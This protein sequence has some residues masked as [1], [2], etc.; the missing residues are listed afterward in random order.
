MDFLHYFCIIATFEYLKNSNISRNFTDYHYNFI[1]KKTV[2]IR[3]YKMFFSRGYKYM[4]T[5]TLKPSFIIPSLNSLVP[6]QI[7]SPYQWPF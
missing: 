1:E 4:V 7:A 5:S 3:S 2:D 6:H